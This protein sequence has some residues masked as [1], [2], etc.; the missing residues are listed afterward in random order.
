MS[1][2]FKINTEQVASETIQQPTIE[3]FDLVA[4][5]DPI[6]REVMPEFDFVNTSVDPGKFASSLV[7][8]C[9]KNQGIGLSANQCGFRH[10]V[11]VMG[12]GD[13]YVAH[14]NPKLLITEGEN[15]MIE[16]C[17]S[18]PLLGLRI[19]RPEIITVE[20]QDFSGQYRTA[21]YAGISARCF[22]HELDHMN[23]IVYTD[24][25]KPMA[26]KSGL[27]K[28]NKI[29]KKMAH[30]QSLLMKQAKKQNGKNVSRTR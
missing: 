26:L 19:T 13:D 5:D 6:L 14:F 20:Y 1:D 11:F 22:L 7:E 10:R 18:F 17:L 21:K 27:D 25:V 2:V 3:T 16:G 8:T 24:R 29:I 9:K 4:E 15:H 30:Y 28:R 23:G 12:A